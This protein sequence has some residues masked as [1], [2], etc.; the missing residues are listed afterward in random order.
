MPDCTG[1]STPICG[2]GVI[3]QPFEQCEPPNSPCA[4]GFGTCDPNCKCVE[5]DTFQTTTALVEIQTPLGNDII[6]L[7]GPTIVRVELGSLADTNGN[8]REEVQTE[9]LQLQLTGTSSLIGPVQVMQSSSRPSKGQ[10]EETTNTISSRLDLPPLAPSGTADSFF[11]VFFDVFVG[12]LVLHNEQPKRMRT[13]I[14]HKPP[15]TGETYEDP[16]PIALLDDQGHQIAVMLS[17][18]HTPNPNLCGNGVLDPG[19]Q[20]DLSTGVYTCHTLVGEGTC[21]TNCICATPVITGP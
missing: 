14:T 7:S 10:I 2:D 1:P 13:I 12:P 6:Q 5:I 20:C 18:S 19:E 9:I 11:D 21:T 8:G 15:A 17:A 3:N 16:T 4:G